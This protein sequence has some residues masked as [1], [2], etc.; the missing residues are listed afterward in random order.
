MQVA[1]SIG[2]DEMTQGNTN[3][4]LA[5][6]YA[7]HGVPVFPCREGGDR[8]KSPYVANGYH[9]ANTQTELLKHWASRYRGALYGLPCAPNNLF[10]LDADRHGN[11][12][13][14]ANLMA[15]FALHG[16]D[17][18]SVPVVHTPGDGLHFI[19]QKPAGLAKTKGTIAAAVDVRDNGYI[20]APGNVLPDGRRYALL[21]G[22]IEQLAAAIAHCSLPFMPEW[23]IKAALRPNRTPLPFKAPA[24][25]E[26]ATG[27]LRRIVQTVIGAPV[28]NRNRI[29]FWA[30]CRIGGLVK[31]GLLRE[32]A[33]C[34]LLLE[35]GQHAGLA[36]REALA[37]SLSGLR[38]GQQDATDVC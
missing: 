23:L 28:G 3:H 14:V 5:Q 11:G 2:G 22:S 25:A 36:Q 33:A 35:A 32:E 7:N 6:T 1:Q 21:N 34:V 4:H 19:F 10:V 15:V 26:A 12:D 30:A 31:Q 8:P 20:I 9:Q 37:T 29:L 18:Q 27:Q 38:Q 13:G 17:W 24:T 16:F